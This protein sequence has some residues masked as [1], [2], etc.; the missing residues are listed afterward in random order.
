MRWLGVVALFG[1]ALYGDD[2]VLP[3]DDGHIVISPE[4]VWNKEVANPIPELTFHLKNQTSS[5]W[6]TIRLQ[7]DIGAFCNGEPQQWKVEAT[8]SL[9]W[10]DNY[11]F[12][13]PYSQAMIF[14]A[15]KIKGCRTEII[16]ARLLSAESSKH[17]RIDGTPGERVDLAKELEIGRAQRADRK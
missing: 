2:I 7:F 6:L 1:A 17:I 3:L 16:K 9:G 5:S 13:K 8:T 12:V 10:A 14:L 15:G 4:L 11:E